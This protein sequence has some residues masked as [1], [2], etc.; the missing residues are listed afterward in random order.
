MCLSAP[1][2]LLAAYHALVRA[3]HACDTPPQSQR[4]T[5]SDS[6]CVAATRP[7]LH[8]NPQH[9]PHMLPH[10]ACRRVRREAATAGWRRIRRA[11]ARQ[12]GRRRSTCVWPCER[13]AA[14]HQNQ[15]DR[16][17][18]WVCCVRCYKGFKENCGEASTHTHTHTRCAQRACPPW[19]A[20]P[21]AATPV[22]QPAWTSLR[23]QSTPQTSRSIMQ[24]VGVGVGIM[25]MVGGCGCGHNADGGCGRGRGG[26][27][28]RGGGEPKRQP[29]CK[30]Y[31]L[32][33]P[34]H[35]A[36]VCA[37]CIAIS[38]P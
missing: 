35:L 7:P 1:M 32:H 23:A 19:A 10:T 12:L 29:P 3:V 33:T 14:G 22:R 8:H 5:A 31:S 17:P 15:S 13:G 16:L 38:L 21:S 20:S 37:L 18:R 25:Q 9:T 26:W 36:A 27:V 24:M 11:P 30:L 4:C 2:S 6:S 34:L 28:Q